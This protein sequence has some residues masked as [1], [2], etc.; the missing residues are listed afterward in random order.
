ME[1]DG[2]AMDMLTTQ[3]A[4]CATMGIKIPADMPLDTPAHQR[5]A[6]R[7]LNQLIGRARRKRDA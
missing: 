1:I 3:F 6:V 2:A 4:T 7:Y 5:A